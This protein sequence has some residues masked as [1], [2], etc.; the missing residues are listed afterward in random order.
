VLQ[1]ALREGPQGPSGVPEARYPALA[2]MTPQEK[3][4]QKL[5]LALAGAG[6]LI[7]GGVVWAILN[8]KE[9]RRESQTTLG[10]RG[11]KKLRARL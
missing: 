6:V 10:I 9:N 3:R 8:R 2:E 5:K 7:A 4:K 1:M 11:T